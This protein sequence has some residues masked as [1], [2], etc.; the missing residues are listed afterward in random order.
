MLKPRKPYVMKR[1]TPGR[2]N[3]TSLDENRILKNGSIVSRTVSVG[4]VN[5]G[6]SY[7]SDMKKIYENN[8]DE[9]HKYLDS[10]MK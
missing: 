4:G 7:D 5:V 2:Y 6:D 9:Y 1:G 10:L 3:K 8:L